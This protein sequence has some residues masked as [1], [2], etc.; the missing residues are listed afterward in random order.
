MTM[1]LIIRAREN[2]N[3]VANRIGLHSFVTYVQGNIMTFSLSSMT[4]LK[5]GNIITNFIHNN[6]I[7]TRCK[8][9]ADKL[10]ALVYIYNT[11]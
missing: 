7:I 11:T 6:V 9:Y 3:I 4:Q 10:S 1:R 2:M 5:G 8:K